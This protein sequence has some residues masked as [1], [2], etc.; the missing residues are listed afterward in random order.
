[1]IEYVKIW[2]WIAIAT[3][4]VVVAL[5]GK[6][7]AFSFVLAM[8]PFL[9][10]LSARY[11]VE[12]PLFCLLM[13]LANGLCALHTTTKLLQY[14][15]HGILTRNMAFMACLF[16]VIPLLNAIYLTP[17]PQAPAAN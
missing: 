8:A 7:S 1:M 3:A 11:L 4:V 16:V 15:D 17:A 13:R 6:A 10:A 5:S 2:N 9:L 14:A 12:S